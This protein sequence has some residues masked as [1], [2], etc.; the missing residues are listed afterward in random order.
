MQ[1]AHPRTPAVRPEA[2]EACHTAADP[3]SLP[4]VADH[5]LPAADRIGPVAAGRRTGLA[6]EDGHT[7]LVGEDHRIGLVVGHR[8]FAA[9]AVRLRDAR[10]AHLGCR[11]RSRLRRA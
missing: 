2:E 11:R 1:A 4:A 5:S 10:T 8:S 6:E 3:D 9:E 7:V